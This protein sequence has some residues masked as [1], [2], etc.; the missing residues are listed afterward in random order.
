MKSKINI[1]HIPSSELNLTHTL[2]PG[3]SF[4]WKQDESNRWIGVVDDHVIR[5]WRQGEA[6]K[7]QSFPDDIDDS[8]IKDYFR[9]EVN[10]SEL[11]KEFSESDLHI[12]GAIERFQGL[13][14][15]R[16]DP[17]ETLFTYICSAANS[18]ARISKSVELLSQERGK[19]ITEIDGIEYY[20]FPKPEK[21]IDMNVNRTMKLCGLGFRC[22]NL[23]SAAKHI[24][25]K[26]EGW[27]NSLRYTDY[28]EAK[29]QLLQ[30]DGVGRKIADCILLFSLDKDQAVPVDTHIRKV[31]V[32][33][34]MPEFK[35]KSLTPIV[36]QQV[37]EY[38][39]NKFGR[40]TG[41]AQEYLFYHDLIKP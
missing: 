14:V 10:L 20:A 17:S 29:N 40:Y 9:L 6:I 37:S 7:Y 1:I 41:W 15:L 16:Q 24:L 36:Y 26:P 4:R 19:Y 3:Q 28:E 39:Q 11:Y 33:Y 13:R 22:R 8:F 18:V 30:I 27:L 5:I 21:L 2:T 31:A 34:Y 32:N 12:R 25:Q 23:H 38:L 35:Q